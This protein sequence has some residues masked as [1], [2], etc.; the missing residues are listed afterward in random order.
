MVWPFLFDARRTTHESRLKII[1]P[2][3][4]SRVPYVIFFEMWLSLF[5][6]HTH[7]KM[8]LD[9]YQNYRLGG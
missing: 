9:V 5:I 3:V 1:L 4:L 8:L 2:C 6:L 7:F